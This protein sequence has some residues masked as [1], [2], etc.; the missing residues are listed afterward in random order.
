MLL[1]AD[2]AAAADVPLAVLVAAWSPAPPPLLELLVLAVERGDCCEAAGGFGVEEVDRSCGE[3]TPGSN[4]QE[5]VAVADTAEV[6]VADACDA[7]AAGF[8]LVGSA[9]ELAGCNIR[10]S[11]LGMA[12]CCGG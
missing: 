12:G 1:L 3:P 4:L 11:P 5:V 8:V 6:E 10:K 7:E 9:G 2:P